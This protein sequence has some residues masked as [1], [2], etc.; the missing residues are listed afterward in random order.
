[1]IIMMRLILLRI[2]LMAISR[3]IYRAWYGTARWKALRAKVIK[4]HPWCVMCRAAHI[5]K[6]ATIAD[7]I[8]PHKGNEQLFWSESNLQA[9]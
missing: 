5:S 8:R 3:D 4:S 2:I 9:L 7:H 1:M 6:R